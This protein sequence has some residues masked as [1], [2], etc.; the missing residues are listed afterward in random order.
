MNTI[1]N[2]NISVAQKIYFVYTCVETETAAQALATAGVEAYLAFCVNI[3][4]QGTS[5][6]WWQKSVNHSQEVYMLFK[7]TSQR[8]NALCTYIKCHHPYTTPF[9]ASSTWEAEENVQNW[10]QEWLNQT[11]SP[12]AQTETHDEILKG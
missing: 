10:I 6:Y 7:T 1:Q 11:P 12:F 4:P 3:F 8:L 9:I 5:V 2:T